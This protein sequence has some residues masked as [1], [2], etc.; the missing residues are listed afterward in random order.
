MPEKNVGSTTYPT[1]LSEGM[2]SAPPL[3]YR[4]SATVAPSVI[5]SPARPRP[6]ARFQTVCLEALDALRP[7]VMTMREVRPAR[8][9]AHH[10]D[11]VQ[12]A[13]TGEAVIRD[14][15]WWRMLVY[16]RCRRGRAV[17]SKATG[18]CG[19]IRG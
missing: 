8:L 14:D 13:S 6:L 3:S 1:I 18:H 9:V 15:R 4:W 10:P 17:T 5:V 7:T 19:V 12:D 16:G 11:V 2:H